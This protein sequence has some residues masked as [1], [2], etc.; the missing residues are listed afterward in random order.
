MRIYTLVVGG[1]ADKIG[2]CGVRAPRLGSLKNDERNIR[3]PPTHPL[4][5]PTKTATA[6]R[7]EPFLLIN[8]QPLLRHSLVRITKRLGYVPCETPDTVAA[9]IDTIKRK[10][11]SRSPKLILM[12]ISLQGVLCLDLLAA[13]RERF[14]SAPILVVSHQPEERFAERALRMG[15][16]GFVSTTSDEKEI[17]AAISNVAKREIHVSERVQR[18]LLKRVARTRMPIEVDP[19]S[20]LSDRELHILH[21]FGNGL[22]PRE[23]ADGLDLSVKTVETYRDRLKEKLGLNTSFELMRYAIEYNL[24]GTG[25]QDGSTPH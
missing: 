25:D 4:A 12:E 14:P 11:N 1:T 15:A 3:D 2:D 10:A 6:S 20:T 18:L 21:Q 19:C 17:E 22:A 7:Q 23:I 8:D 5:M 16:T 24:F 9:V 13:I